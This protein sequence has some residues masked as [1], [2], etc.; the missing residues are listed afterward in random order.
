MSSIHNFSFRQNSRALLLNSLEDHPWTLGADLLNYMFGKFPIYV[1]L[2]GLLGLSYMLRTDTAS[3]IREDEKESDYAKRKELYSTNELPLPPVRPIWEHALETLSDPML[4]VLMIGGAVSIAANTAK[5]PSDGWIEGTAILISVLIVTFVSS[6]NNYSQEVAFLKLAASLKGAPV[7]IMRGHV[8]GTYEQEEILVGDVVSLSPGNMIPAD[9]VMI[10]QTT[11]TVNESALTGESHELVKGPHD[12]FLS[13]GTE[14]TSGTCN[15]LVTAVGINSAKG[16]LMSSLVQ[17]QRPTQLQERLEQTAAIIGYIGLAASVL[18]FL[19]LTIRFIVNVETKDSLTWKD[20]WTQIIDFFIIS[21]TII[22]VAIPEGLP[23]AVTVSLAYSMAKMRKDQNLVKVLSACETMGNA[24]AICSDKTGTLTQNKMTV[25]QSFVAGRFYPRQPKREELSDQVLN[26]LTDGVICNSD[27]RVRE[28]RMDFSVPPEDWKWEGDGGA[29]ES[30]LLAWLSRY[31]EPP[32][33]N[34]MRLRVE[35]EKRVMQ[36]F[37]FSSAKKHSSVIMQMHEPDEQHPVGTNCRRYYKGAADRIIKAC[38]YMVDQ[39]GQVIPVGDLAL[40][41]CQHPNCRRD[42]M[43][44]EIPNTP[45][46]CDEHSSP[47]M[48]CDQVCRH[49]HNNQRCNKWAVMGTKDGVAMYCTDPA[50]HPDG[51]ELYLLDEH[52]LKLM[53]NMTRSGLRCIAVAYV[54]GI[55]VK[56]K[57]GILSEPDEVPDW[58]LV[59]FVGIKDPLRPETRD[60]VMTV[61]QAGIVVRMVTGD[62]L[63]TAKF[64]AQD[65]GI[66]TDPR[67]LALEGADF[68]MALEEQE[69]YKQKNGTDDPNFVQLVKNLRVMARCQPEDKLELVKFLMEHGEVVGVTGDGSND[70]PALK[71]ADVGLAMGIAGTDVAK[72]AANIIILD[73]N[74]SS[75]VKSVLWG[76]CVYDNIRKFLQ[77]QCAVNFC[78]LGLALVGAIANGEEPLKAVQLLWVNLIMDTMGALALGTEH[79]KPVLLQRKPYRPDCPLISKPMWRNIIGQGACQLA[80]LLVI[81]YEGKHWFSNR[82][83]P[84]GVYDEEYHFT[85]IFNTFVWCQF[86]NEINSRKVNTEMNIFESMFENFWFPAV[87]AITAGFQILMVEVFGSFART[88]HQEWDLWLTAIGFGAT[89]LVTG[90]LL[91]LFIRVDTSEDQLQLDSSTFQGAAWIDNPKLLGALFKHYERKADGTL[92]KQQPVTTRVDDRVFQSPPGTVG[93]RFTS[94]KPNSISATA[95]QSTAEAASPV[96]ITFAE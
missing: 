61:Q 31:Y 48:P 45:T 16:R 30:A 58:T 79:P 85:Y 87:L 92:E 94:N 84:N 22:V 33:S 83:Y 28:D 66:I 18:T 8:Q 12:P 68:R 41:K 60:A 59:G 9:G 34:I 70:G 76:R 80:I 39:N 47:N 74:F 2:G 65:C 6:Y 88:K 29:T 95:S 53:G 89:Q 42:A 38:K 43:R 20:D 52:P 35:N 26:L 90:F 36:F 19:A 73:D 96:R 14:I 7:T 44:G 23:L 72:A 62:N 82:F 10:D 11:V 56:I 75:I 5:H 69:R 50:H 71:Q 15:M 27:R 24:T 49:V 67:H 51:V 4:I 37:P 3:G 78:A 55:S 21:V 54:D 57:D 91:R 77:F 13:A 32:R 93:Y 46:H 81:L 86:F 64:I 63:D 40:P 25:V 1:E 17:E